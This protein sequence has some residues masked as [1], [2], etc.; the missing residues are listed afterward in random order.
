MSIRPVVVAIAVLLVT[1]APTAG[2]ASGGRAPLAV[3]A[4]TVTQ[5]GEQ[6]TWAVTTAGPF[7]PAS[8]A[9]EGRSLCLLIERAQDGTVT[10]R[11]CLQGPSAHG[12]GAQL[13][14]AQIT[15]AGPGP[16][17]VIAATVKR[18]SSSQLTATFVPTSFGLPYRNIRWQVI[19]T[20]K[21]PTCV[22][23]IP[24]RIG[25]YALFPAAPALAQLHAPQL[26]GCVAS[27]PSLVYNGP[28]DR[29]EVALT[30]DDG[31]W[32]DPP[33]A[34]FV[35]LLEREH[36]VGTFFE[37]GRQIA[38][39]D[40][41]GLVER[42]M[43]A[44]GDMIGDHTWS[45]PTMTGLSPAAQTQEL[46]STADAIKQ[47]THGFTPCLWRPP[48]GAQDP[49]LDA[50]AR[51]LG[52]LTIMWNVDPRDWATPGVDAIYDNV[53]ANARNGSIVIQHFGGGPRQQTLAALPLEIAT[54]R[55]ERY[56]FVTV[57]Q[58]LGLKLIY[59]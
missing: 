44:D 18:P 13:V 21:P 8:L 36:A 42:E 22:P 57:A 23:P 16:G 26:V 56:Q 48:Y 58:L 11:L 20:L 27:G 39:Y 7:S 50:L 49:S 45:H 25:C 15:A 38:G 37:I 17:L 3:S 33:S 52:M 12:R 51:S 59:K 1:V 29:H 6:V 31:P 54:L 28:P 24:N 43:L 41:G 46:Q 35:A 32:N 5:D 34:Q 14:Y 4:S 10:A 55:R 40:P 19:S 2:A 30:F 47:A 9:P 53:V